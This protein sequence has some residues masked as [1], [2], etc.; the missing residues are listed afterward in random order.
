[1]TAEDLGKTVAAPQE[2]VLAVPENMLT[3]L[4]AQ[5]NEQQ[6][7]NEGTGLVA[8]L[9]YLD[10]DAR[11][12]QARLVTATAFD[13][14]RWTLDGQDAPK[15]WAHVIVVHDER[16]VRAEIAAKRAI[17]N[18]HEHRREPV[19]IRSLNQR[20]NH[21]D[22]MPGLWRCRTCHPTGGPPP[23]R[24]WCQTVRQLCSPYVSQPGY[25]AEWRP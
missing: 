25:R 10:E 22:T 8:W 18:L 17:L 13:P 23:M 24:S 7:D 12:A 16:V 9:T 4:R 6:Y 11:P 21:H 19:V 5:L 15:G 2:E 14:E 3:W 20:A 1:L